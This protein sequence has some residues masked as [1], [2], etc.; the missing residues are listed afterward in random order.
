MDISECVCKTFFEELT[1]FCRETV[2]VCNVSKNAAPPQIF[3]CH[4]LRTVAKEF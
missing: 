1:F 2:A 4:T 3:F